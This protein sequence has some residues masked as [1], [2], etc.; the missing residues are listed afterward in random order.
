MVHSGPRRRRARDC[1]EARRDPII[2]P[3]Q[4]CEDILSSRSSPNAHCF[5]QGNILFSNELARRYGSEGIV[6]TS[7]HPGAIN[8]ELSRN[9]GSLTQRF[10]R[11]MSYDVSYVQSP[12]CMLVP[13]L[14]RADLMARWDGMLE[15]SRPTLWLTDMTFLVSHGVGTRRGAE[16]EGARHRPRE[17]AVG[18]V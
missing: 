12:P 5:S 8:T 15:C 17:K 3:E 9:T 7:L 16:Q 6:S 13:H 10:Q 2:Q 11:L 14:L 4:T 1:Q 18:V